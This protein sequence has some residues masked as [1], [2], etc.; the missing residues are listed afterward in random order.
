M[1]VKCISKDS[2]QSL[3]VGK[4]YDVVSIQTNEFGNK[5]YQV[6]ND[7]NKLSTYFPYKFEILKDNE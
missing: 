7:N 2:L 4:V 6:M 3:T 1:K 5:F